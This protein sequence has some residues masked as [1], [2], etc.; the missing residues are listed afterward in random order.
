[1][2]LIFAPVA[3]KYAWPSVVLA[4]ENRGL[5]HESSL[6]RL[7]PCACRRSPRGVPALRWIALGEL[8]VSLGHLLERAGRVR[9][10]PLAG[11]S[12]LSDRYGPG[13]VPRGDGPDAVA[14]APCGHSRRRH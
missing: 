10:P 14:Y 8:W 9:I 4:G 7:H 5:A 12:H 11:N 1:M 6:D 13:R 3:R 2:M